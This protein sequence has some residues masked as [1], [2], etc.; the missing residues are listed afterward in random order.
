MLYILL[1]FY[2][3]LFYLK[4]GQI[5]KN[6]NFYGADVEYEMCLVIGLLI[7]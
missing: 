2:W 1:S 5:F 6:I 7:A 4:E 3:I